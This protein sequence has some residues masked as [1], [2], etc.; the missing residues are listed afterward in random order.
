MSCQAHVIDVPCESLFYQTFGVAPGKLNVP[1]PQRRE[2]FLL[3]IFAAK[4][5]CLFGN[6]QGSFQDSCRTAAKPVTVPVGL[7]NPL[8]LRQWTDSRPIV[9]SIY[10]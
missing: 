6:V 9:P 4:Q 3:L 10:S 5:A 8:Y 1:G 7:E 2:K